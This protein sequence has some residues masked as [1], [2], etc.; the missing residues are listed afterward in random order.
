MTADPVR[1][2]LAA[3]LDEILPGLAPSE[4]T[5]EKS[6]HELG[7]DSVDRVEIVTALVH[8]LGVDRPVTD[9]A[10]I[11]DIGALVETLAEGSTR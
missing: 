5:D 8:R 9:F 7:A 4:V 10:D 2:A 1:S 6:L 11:P 3:V